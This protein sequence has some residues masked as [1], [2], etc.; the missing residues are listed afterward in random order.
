MY[1]FNI[2]FIILRPQFRY[3]RGHALFDAA[4]IKKKRRLLSCLLC[5]LVMSPY[6]HSMSTKLTFFLKDLFLSFSFSL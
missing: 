3:S 1:F 2:Y 5:L 4:V 6:R